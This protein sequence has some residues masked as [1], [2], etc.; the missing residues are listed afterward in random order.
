MRMIMQLQERQDAL[1]VRKVVRQPKKDA[2]Q[3]NRRVRQ[4]RLQEKKL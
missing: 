3:L 2:K 4:L 1:P